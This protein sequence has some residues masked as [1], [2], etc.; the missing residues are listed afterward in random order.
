[1]LAEIEDYKTVSG[2]WLWVGI[3]ILNVIVVL[4]VIAGMVI[5][6]ENRELKTGIIPEEEPE[7][8][9]IPPPAEI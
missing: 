7:P 1:M 6:Y 3:F 9:Y 8:I 2:K 5:Y 4:G